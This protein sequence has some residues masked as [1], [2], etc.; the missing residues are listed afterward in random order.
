VQPEINSSGEDADDDHDQQHFP[1]L[2]LRRLTHEYRYA[3]REHG[4]E[5]FVIQPSIVHRHFAG[6]IELGVVQDDFRVQFCGQSGPGMKQGRLADGLIIRRP[7]AD[8]H[9]VGTGVLAAVEL[10]VGLGPR[11]HKNAR[12]KLQCRIPQLFFLKFQRAVFCIDVDRLA[13]ADFPFKNV[14]AERVENFFLNGTPKR[15]G[16]V[17]RIVSFAGEQFLGRI[18]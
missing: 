6:V 17:N 3:F 5:R 10:D 12:I 9:L 13:F 2:N 16:T 1:G 18:G 4:R 14:D 11:A 15:S 7:N 8:R